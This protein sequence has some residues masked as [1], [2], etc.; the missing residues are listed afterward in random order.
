MLMVVFCKDGVDE[1]EEVERRVEDGDGDVL[2]EDARD[3]VTTAG[4]EETD[5]LDVGVGAATGE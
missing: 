2:D 3:V 5:G 4:F 1:R